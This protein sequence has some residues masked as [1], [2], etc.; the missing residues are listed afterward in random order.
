L[1]VGAAIGLA[2]ML[3][4][5]GCATK[6][7]VSSELAALRTEMETK[8]QDLAA[9]L[10]E[11]Q[12]SASE[13][14]A[15]AE[16]A[17]GQAGETRDLALGRVGYRIAD[18]YSVHF[19]LDSAELTSESVGLLNEVGARLRNHPEYLVDVYG[20]TDA[21]GSAA[22]NI[23]LG[24]R[25]A[26]SVVRHLVAASPGELQRFAAVSFGMESASANGAQSRR[27]DVNLVL[28][29]EPLDEVTEKH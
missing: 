19:G 14:L 15:R 23:A 1:F 12:N 5:S 22:Y 26:E 6:G 10:D 28:R 18:T 29:I 9:A 17:A 3:L 27:V 21:T 24:Q 13:A 8:D 2:A 16:I 11:V 4:L 20:F 25:R 7:F